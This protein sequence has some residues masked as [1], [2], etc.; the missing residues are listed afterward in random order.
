MLIYKLQYP[1]VQ[2]KFFSGKTAADKELKR[3]RRALKTE[4]GSVSEVD[5]TG[6]KAV[7]EWLNNAG[8]A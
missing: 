8:A 3:L 7:I 6:K 5:I 4:D 2:T 1:G